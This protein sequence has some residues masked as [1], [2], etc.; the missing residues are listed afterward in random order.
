MAASKCVPTLSLNFFLTA[1]ETL[2]SEHEMP[3]DVPSM[4]AQND[5]Q[6]T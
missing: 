4:R 6:V 3:H 5:S 1:D 2:M